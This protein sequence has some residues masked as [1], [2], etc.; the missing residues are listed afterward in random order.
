[1]GNEELVT[2]PKFKTVEEE[3]LHRKNRLAGAFRLFSKFGFDEGLAGHITVRDPEYTDYFWVNPFAVHFSLIQTSDLV[4]VNEEGEVVEG[5]TTAV[6]KAAL[7]IHTP[8]HK[9]RPDVDAAAHTHG[10]YGKTWS[11]LGRLLDPINQDACAFYE[12]HSIIADYNGVVYE[13]EE[14]QKIVE[15]LGNRKGVILGNHGLLTVGQSV[16]EAAWWYISM[17]R[18]CQSQLMAESVGKPKLIDHEKAKLT[19]QQVGAPWAGEAQF[20]LL[21]DRIVKEQPDLLN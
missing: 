2:A 9:A 5:K 4:L 13:G 17:E 11:T 7:A 16:E 10:L 19:S 6:N 20:N 12:D 1:M 21:Y 3:R 8:I 15:T 14:G 18:C